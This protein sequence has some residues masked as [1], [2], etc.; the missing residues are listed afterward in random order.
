MPG[1]RGEE[2]SRAAAWESGGEGKQRLQL[3]GQ[4]AEGRLP[5]RRSGSSQDGAGA[6]G[7]RCVGPQ[8]RPAA[9]SQQDGRLEAMEEGSVGPEQRG[10]ARQPE[11]GAHGSRAWGCWE[12]DSPRCFQNLAGKG[13]GK[14]SRGL[15]T[16]D[17]SGL[18]QESGGH[19][20]GPQ[21]GNTHHVLSQRPGRRCPQA[22]EA[23]MRASSCLQDTLPLQKPGKQPEKH[24]TWD[25]WLPVSSPRTLPGPRGPASEWYFLPHTAPS[26]T[27]SSCSINA[28]LSQ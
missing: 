6:L 12:R 4:R 27:H 15:S 18:G 25:S 19:G 9:I 22:Q 26:T 17:L 16:R 20:P 14:A 3:P 1:P 13:L 8:C 2:G 24:A 28:W 23:A 11:R 5:T 7:P 21:H 10:Q